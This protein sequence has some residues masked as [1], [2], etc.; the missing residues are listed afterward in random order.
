VSKGWLYGL[1]KLQQL[2][3]AYN[4]VNT[5]STIKLKSREVLR[6]REVHPESRIQ[7]I[8]EKGEKISSKHPPVY[9]FFLFFNRHRKDS[10]Y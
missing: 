5:F 10:S 2:S 9:Y 7:Q 4:K 3:L 6:I 1:N 8:K